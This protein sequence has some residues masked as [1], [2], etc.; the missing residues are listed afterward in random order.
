[1]EGEV[2]NKMKQIIKKCKCGV[3]LRA[4]EHKDYYQTVEQYLIEQI[5]DQAEI[6]EIGKD[7]WNK[8]IELDTIF[9]LQFYPNTPV[10]FYKIFHYDYDK[11]IKKALDILT[12]GK[13]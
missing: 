5:I 13:E 2:E 1:M 6:D 11:L 3:F 7:V 4:N 9:I 10:G 8:M 12:E